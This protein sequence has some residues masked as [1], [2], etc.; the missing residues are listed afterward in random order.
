MPS[1]YQE[2][3][4]M[5]DT[6]ERQ[7][8]SSYK[9]WTQFLRT[10]AR[11]YKYPYNEQV[12][13]HAQRPDA[14]ACA[15]YDFWNKKMGR[16]IRRGSTGI[17][18]I[19]T[20]G[21]KPQ[22]RYVFDVADTGERE[23]SRPV[24]LWRFRAEHEDI[25]AATLE[26]SYDVSVSDGIVEQMESAATQLAKE[27]WADHKRDILHNI[28]DSY[29]DGYDEFN[30]EVQFRNAAKV[31]ITYMLM[32]RCR[33]EPEAYLEPEDFMP[34]F[35]FNTPAAV[36][37]LGTA[38]SEIS[39]QVLRQIEV[40][41]RNYE[42]ER[43]QNH[44]RID[45]HEE[46]RLP[47][48]RP[49]A[50]RGT[51]EQATGQV[52]D[53]AEDLPSGASPHPLE[54]DD[55]VR[56]AVPAP[57]GDRRDG[58]AEIGADDAGADEVGRRDGES[59]N[60]RPDEMGRADEHLQG[61]GR[62]NHSERAGVQLT[63]DAPEV[64]PVQPTAAYQMSLF[65]TEEEQI[66]YIDTAE[67]V[68]STP[69][70]FSMFISQD[71][72]D[73]ILRTGGNAD[74]ARMKIVA[75]F[76]KQKPIED[77][78]AFL[79]NLYYGGNGLIT[80]NGRF[81]AWY[82]DDGIHIAN[83]DAARHLRSAQVI[84]WADAAER[85][86]ALLD[87]GKFATDLEVTEA[88]RYERLGI[89]VDVW[90][91][92]H[93]FSDEAKSLGYLSCLGNIH[94]TNF[95]EETERLTDDLL[96]PE[97]REQFLTEYK[98]FLDAYRENRE[99]LRFH[100]HRPQ[101]LLTRLEDLSLPRKEY[102]S[103]MAAVPKTGRFITEDE[104]AASLANGSGFEG[105]K[106]R[107]YEFFQ[108]PHTPKESADFLKKEYGIGGRTHAVSRESGSYEDHGSKGITLRK[109][110]CA[111]IQMN[112][113]KVASRISEL[114]RTN[115]YLTPDEQAAYDKENEQDALRNA[116]YDDYNDVKAAHP[117]EIVLYQVGDFFE[118]YG[119]DARAVA[120]DLSLELTRRNLEGVG[121]VT[122]CGFPAKDLEKYVEKLREKHDVTISRIGDS[123]HEH[124]AYT[125]PSIDHEAEDAIN[126]YEAEF[127][128]DGTRVFRDPAAEQAQPTVQERLERYRPIVI[129]T[130]SE[131]TAYRNAC[132]HSDREN[133]EI[134]CNAAVRRAVLNSKDM[135]LIRLFSD[136][137]E[138]RSRLHQEVFEGTY[139]RLHDLLRPL[140]QDDIDDALRAWNGNIE[141]K[142]AVVRYMQQHGRE[143]ETAA[144]LAYE[145]GGKEGNNL[146]IVRAG[147][148][149]AAE[150]SWAKV[151]RRIAQLIRE[152]KFF[153][154]QEKS[155]L[156]NNP[157]YRLLGRLRADCEY[158]LGAGNRA[159]KH[160]W[161]GSVY[162][163]IVKM[164]ELYDALPQKPEWLT[165]E[166]IDDY[167]ERMAPR[168]QVVA[169]HHFENGFDEKLD[170]QTLEEAEK[171]AQGYVDGT[172]ESDGFAYDGA[173][174]YDQ[175]ARKYLRIY[176][177]YP[178]ER[179]HAEVAGRELVEELAVS[180]EST[181]VPADRFHVV[182]LDRGFRTLYAVWDDETHGYYV[183]ADGVTEE[184]TSEW[185]AEAYRLELQGQAEQALMERAK[186]LISDFCR[187]E[188]GSEADFS[189]PTKVGVA[190]T[191]VTDD[192]IP[193]QVN[194][195]LVNYRLERY[196]DDAHLETRQY[197]SLQELIT[198][199]LEN[200]DFS[201]LIHVSDEDVEQ[202]RWHEPEAQ[203]AEHPEAVE[204]A[205]VPQREPF[206]YSVGDTVYLE[207]GKP[208]I[209]ESIGLFDISLR[210]PS[211]RYPVSRAESRE[212]FARLM[213]RYPQPEQVP[214]YTEETVA[215]YPGDKNSLPYDVEIRTLRF[216]EPEHDPPSAEPIETEPPAMSEEEALILEQEGRA[217]LSEMG[218]FVPDFDDAISQAEIDEPPAH[219][220]AVSIPIDGEWQD[221]PSVAA[222]EQAAYADFKAA[223]HRNAQNFHITD[224]ALGVGGAKA[225]FRA[226]MAAI[227][228]LQ[229]LEF[230]GL[231][232]SPEQ[233][234][235][236]SR[237][238]GWGGLADAFDENKPNWS[239]E[240]AELYATLSPEEYAA[241]RASTLNAHY[242]SPTVIKAI[243]EAVGN[244]GFQTG[245]I[246]EPSMGVGNF[247][248]LLPEQMQGSKLYGVEL[249][250]IT[251]RIAKQLYPKADITIAGF[252]TTDRKD[253]YDLAV[254]N[255]PFGQYQVDDRAYNKLGFSIHDYFFAK[256]LDQVR[257]GGVIAF[258]TS[259]YTMDKQSPEVRRYIAQRA[260][261]L[262]AIRLPNNA[263]RAN[264][265]T[266][267]VSDII[268]LQ[269]RDRPIEID[270]DWIHLGQSE[271]GFA[272]NSYFA[273]HPEMVLGTPSSESTQYGKQDY[274]VNPIEGA[275]LGTLLHEAVQNIGGK[276]QEAE[277]PDLGE[278]EKIG[279]SIPADPNVKNFSYTI[280]DG[281]V[282]YRENSVMVKPDLN[283]TAKAR[284]KGMVQLRDCVQK[285][286]GQ[287]MDGFVSDEAIQRTQREL[288]ALYDSFTA[289]YGLINTRANN[290]AFSDD[291][292]YFLLCSLEML[293]EENNLKRKA[294]IFT[295]RTIRPHEA[296]TSVDTASE[297]LA[298][299]ISE[300]ARVDM[301]YMAQL[302][303]KSQEELID[304]LNGV[305]F[306][307]P[308]HGEWQTA[309]EYLSGD[310]RQ[311][312]REAEAAAKDSPGY[313]P[314]VEALRQAQPK[315][316]DASEIEVRLGA[317]WIDKAYIKQ[318]MFELLEPA[319]YVRRSIDV[320][321]S[322][323][324]AE[325]NITGK[326]VV[327]RSDIN[328]NMTYGTERANAYKILEDTL[329]LRDVRIYD[330]ITDADGKEKR[331]LNS[332]ETTLAQQKQQA[333]KDA[334]QEWIWK[335][336][337]RRHELVQKY[338]E[339]F[340]ATRPREYN[341]QHI[342]F[343]GMNPEIQLREHQLNAV[344][345]ILYGGN[346]LLA[347]EVGAG[348]TFEMVAA[349]ME[350]KRLGLCHK[351]MFVV[352]NHLIEQW[353]SEFLRLYPSA[354]ILAVT[355]KDFEP[356]N[357]KKF[358]ARI[359]TGDYDAV[360]IGHSQF[361]RIP[362]SRERQERMLQEQIYEIEDG[363]M[364]LRANN[365]ERFTIK[366]LE[367]TKKSLEVK[368]KKLQDTSRKDD[369]ITFE[370]L[371]VD[372]LYVD[373]AHAFKNLFLYTKM[374]NVAGLS[375]SDAQKS[376]DMLLKCRYI[377][378][379]TGNKGI[380]F[381]TGTPVSNSMT[382]LYTMMRYLQ[383]DMLQRKH[384]THFDC[385]AS[386]FGETATAIE[387]APEG[388]GYRARTRFSKF[389]NLPELMQLFKEA[390][391]I[392]TADQLHLPTP[393]PIYHN[394]VA[395]PTEIQKDMVQELSE[396]AA[397]VHAGI[398]DASTDNMLKI[399]SDGRKL[400]LDQRVINPD[401][402]DEAGS[403]VNLCVDNI[404]S[405][406][407]DGQADKLTQLVFCDLST[408][409]AAVP[410][411][412]AA[413]AAGGNLDSPELH[414]LEAA[415]GQD[416]AEEPAFTIYDDIREKLVA[417]G[418]PREQIAFIHEANTEVRKKELFAK[419]RAGQVRVLM[420]STFKMG[421]GMNVQDRLVA[422]HDL[423]CPWR[424][425]DLEQ[426]SGRIIRQGNRNKE[427]HIYRYV[428]ESTFD[429]YLWQT[430]ENKQKF[431]SQIMTS[432]SPVRSCEDVDETALSYAEIKA[433][434]AGDERIKE[435][436]DLD[437]D[438]ARLKLMKASHQSQQYKLEDS[439]LKKFPEDIEKSRGFISG[440]EADMKTLAA[441]P[442]PEDGFAGMTVK[443]DNLTD[444][445]NAGAALLEAFKDV[446]GM[447]P[448]PIG[449]YRGFQMSL[450]LED[451]GKDYVLTLKG[452]M[453]HRVTL[454]KDAR[455]NL[456]RIDNV[457]NAMPD[458]L[459]NVRN[460][461]DATT[462]Q[463][464]AAKAE[465]GKPFPQE[466]ELRVKSARL[467]ELNAELNIDERTPMEQ[468]ADDAAISAKAERPSVLA[469][470][471]NTPTRQ[472][473]DTPEK[474]REQ[475]SR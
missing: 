275:D 50:E 405:V 214:T 51:G 353:A 342:T 290:L 241:A 448:V 80:E 89:A 354:N 279:T 41:I 336:P 177:N 232:A 93:D 368:L 282:Y 189:D 23:H 348:K 307:N 252:E 101:A 99:L 33:L 100:F 122:M 305:I 221:F 428:T 359:A 320:N 378:E 140:S 372:R 10:A 170:Y 34:V 1:K 70:A 251:G 174:I 454:G 459:Q 66:A 55:P 194:I 205:P 213:E 219:R 271:N 228:L 163:Q 375:T 96:N 181:I 244:M 398:V 343:S 325:W 107:I 267:V 48:S 35:D 95:P 365:A 331:V 102:H 364:E 278:N 5:A 426:R 24:H 319:F 385:W 283:A 12:M 256:T 369:V 124:T 404:Y 264:A 120:D 182:S 412:R 238:V 314:N 169:Y 132:G 137:P 328:A 208:F 106:A 288:D 157:D 366:S 8:T 234:E 151:Q 29:L 78:A 345:H 193:I 347:H 17:A 142:R 77:Y 53:A 455:G 112:W 311:K 199:E 7:L 127:G 274:T 164:R 471:K 82:G 352:P 438:V 295:K 209:I 148:P 266:D 143:K 390:A 73:H 88:P 304:E 62:R 380:V 447:E 374:R 427:V 272:I 434:C 475:E 195:D 302:S 346:T 414:A 277:L 429:A 52:R 171:A 432:K 393:T 47:D 136:V 113:N 430:V 441:H 72:I 87:D 357:R 105:G 298:L 6:A 395:Q 445:D 408:P 351:P 202:Y 333:I 39:Q 165:K 91:L 31:S 242:T 293:D 389:F 317:T 61:A 327:G 436:M 44:D 144:W 57:A 37:A 32:S 128:A 470:L 36:A 185:Q 411:S 123:G 255:V 158:F 26:R 467:A 410:A 449:T 248:G 273:E 258:V 262:G 156:E 276:Y 90:N 98:I 463:M 382:E 145:Y 367:K 150:L 118:L 197:G 379:I 250:S 172:M 138:F 85:I 74:D 291:S 466:E 187:S 313:L 239:D 218:E 240:F 334:F 97:F 461:L 121:R 424:P 402:P 3:R 443:N 474:Q 418:I 38:V 4:Q 456:T 217:A 270:E 373:E 322:D 58:K 79:K 337:T 340:N 338:N 383:H 179:A 166:M 18:L 71:D 92:Y 224:D 296:I 147:S 188:Y 423:D 421:A 450:T 173:A 344:A 247:F 263:F 176:G 22:L 28:D 308:V 186:G 458:R 152:D 133:A 167:A 49:E 269:R 103:D 212:S 330:T 361:E 154:E 2:Y 14:T 83:G 184:F 168:Y 63:N 249:D 141:S 416:T 233:Q 472:T 415:I 407:K 406:W 399:T 153:T 280:V 384:L 446:R 268:F 109:A 341:G 281:D 394:V 391:D 86:E 56:D 260:E 230:E 401:L 9:S 437:V 431:I 442:H 265:G 377:D 108:T 231:Q 227:H 460:T 433:L 30:T 67:S 11:L 376:S 191:T 297:A 440:L 222:A 16:F 125:L 25:V 261:L 64:E 178:D 65:P 161:A 76:S 160:L 326:S 159:E 68:N 13:I 216:G 425:G 400:G 469:R 468:L 115:R 318:F 329:N 287:Q 200:L 75:E 435:K 350:S 235:I 162:A 46:R 130:V 335:D 360:I 396:R 349:A 286:I 444:K 175:Q 210:D 27:Y 312:L 284:V 246:L 285:L 253:F 324:S 257:P 111:D 149:E 59:E 465:L 462:A 289:K 386:T 229:E 207:D 363:L 362:V 453:T 300:K 403:K 332:K 370:Q 381:A 259:R 43:S 139:A 201:D 42:R 180:M 114:V 126:A 81:S 439:L 387:L 60:Q 116:V 339:L 220:P 131:D 129:A 301:N 392:K 192:E 117:D 203:A 358:C 309:D 215:V 310:V 452:Q 134:E 119:E 419:V 206:P 315:D 20:S 15:E 388:T 54:P 316:L 237:Y 451:F 226:N 306:L 457:L 473:Q 292:S 464:E 204:S 223:S 413:K 19:D 321:Y 243:Y 69:S 371:G 84:S 303:G 422:L 420:G 155:L 183:D 323:F 225:K 397:K 190:Y 211:L 245:N 40:A 196:L 110:G 21:Q 299:S 198:N 356:R 294:D 417:R 236:L 409:K 254:G 146:F 104:I 94:S 355:K 135:E 45:L